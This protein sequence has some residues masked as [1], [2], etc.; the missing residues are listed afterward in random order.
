MDELQRLPVYLGPKIEY[1]VRNIK[2][3]LFVKRYDQ[4]EEVVA[5][6]ANDLKNI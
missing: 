1:N 5:P 2:G 4:W 6:S 3:G